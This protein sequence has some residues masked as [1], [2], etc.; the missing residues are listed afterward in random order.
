MI[1]IGDTSITEGNAPGTVGVTVT[2]DHP[3]QVPVSVD[4][5]TANGTATSPADYT[6]ST[7]TLTI[8]SG[9]TGS[10]NIAV[11]GD[12]VAEPS[13]AFIVTI[14]NATFG[15]ISHDVAIVTIA[16]D[17]VA[18]A[19]SVRRHQLDHRRRGHRW[20]PDDCERADRRRTGGS[21]GAITVRVCRHRRN[22]HHRRRLRGFHRHHL[23]PVRCQLGL[24]AGLDHR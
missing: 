10:I 4:W 9:T 8:P 17:D 12:A 18:I 11:A 20:C 2:L 7:G 21:S 14:S 5:T 16:D 1:S 23:D 22:R 15:S 6:A 24:G 13:E 19:P 3:S